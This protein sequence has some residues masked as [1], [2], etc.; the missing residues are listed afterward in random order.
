MAVRDTGMDTWDAPVGGRNCVL[1]MAGLGNLEGL[2][3]IHNNN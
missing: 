3:K 2:G 1:A